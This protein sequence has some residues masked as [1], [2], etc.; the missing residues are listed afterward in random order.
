MKIKEAKK[1]VM[2]MINWQFVLMGIMEME[3]CHEKTK[4]VD[5]KKYSLDELILAN[6]KVKTNNN[7]KRKLQE[8]RRKKG[9][10]TNGIS[11]SI[12][13]DDRLIAAIYTMLNFDISDEPVAIY[14][15]KGIGIVRMKY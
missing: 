1:I 8:S 6:K 4:E 12:V 5:L 15:E 9:L 11:Q 3:E 7:F 10:E 13:C 14:M 2:S